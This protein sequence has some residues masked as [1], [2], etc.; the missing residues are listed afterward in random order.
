LCERDIEKSLFISDVRLQRETLQKLVREGNMIK[1]SW[2]SRELA[3]VP[4]RDRILLR[5][6]DWPG[7]QNR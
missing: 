2:H 6:Q 7:R 4:T 3:N 5:E 1:S